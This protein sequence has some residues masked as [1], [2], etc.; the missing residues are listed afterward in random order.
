[1]VL[2]G[3]QFEISVVTKDS[4]SGQIAIQNAIDEIER[5][6]NLISEWRPQTQISKVN[7]N[8]GIQA[9]KVDDEIIELT[10]RAIVF[11]ELSNGA[12]D[13]SF[14]SIDKVW[15]F[16]KSM[17]KLP[18]KRKIRK[19][20]EKIDYRNIL[21]DTIH[22]TLF[23]KKKG[24][25]IGFGST[26]K[27]YAADKAK[28][29]LMSQGIEAGLINASGD[30]SCWGF[31][32]DSDSWTVGITNPLKKNAVF[33]TVPLHGKS[34]T[35]SGNYE[36]FAT[37]NGKRYTHIIDPRSGWPVQGLASVTVFGPSA[38]MCNGFST[39]IMVLG[40]E[41]GLE[42]LNQ[43]PDYSGILISDSGE[44]STSKNLSAIEN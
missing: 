43:Y 29:L 11:S 15:K 26:G 20:V 27:G 22:Q 13:I 34:V 14:A 32:P 38:E 40:Q 10:R 7:Q 18:S 8:A 42:M 39:S 31:P 16:D 4:V 41:K 33:A 25:K 17:T 35:T 6:E 12:F 37:I 30:I 21:I 28:E 19:S 9:V 24:M 3:S 2:M 36:K 1:M 44:I 23:L 5:I